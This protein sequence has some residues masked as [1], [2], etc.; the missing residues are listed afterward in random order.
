M[1]DHVERV[2]PLVLSLLGSLQATPTGGTRRLGLLPAAVGIAAPFGRL[3]AAQL[4]RVVSLAEQAGAADLRLSPWRSLY[5]GVRSEALLAG[6]C[7]TGLIVDDRDPLL[8]I[9][10]CPGAPDC[11]SSTVETRSDA[12]LLA[13]LA[14]ACGYVGSIHVSGCA[15]KCACSAVSDLTLVGEEGRYRLG[16]HIVERSDFPRLLEL[17][18]HD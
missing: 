16:T 12:R 13:V 17:A 6:A 1:R 9:E 5:L 4:Q 11:R 15:K 7:S 8:R 2:K 14:A 3:A 18:A 10:A